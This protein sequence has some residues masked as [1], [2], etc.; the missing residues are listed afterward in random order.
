MYIADV[1]QST[2]EEVDFAPAN[3]AGR[4]YGWRL[5]EGANCF[6]PDTGCDATVENLVLPIASYGREVGQSITGGYVYRGPSIPNLRGT[7]LYADYASARFFALRVSGGEVVQEQT[8]ISADLNPDGD[9]EGITSFG[10]DNAG[11]LYV[12]SFGGSVYRIEGE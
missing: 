1:G 4:N 3:A 2:L 7:Y 10:Q 9:V 6:N 12:L 11:E 5:M 8:D